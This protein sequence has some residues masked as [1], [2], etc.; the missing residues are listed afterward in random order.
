MCPSYSLDFSPQEIGFP[1]DLGPTM[2]VE[3]AENKSVF[4]SEI[5][6]IGSFLLKYFL[7]NVIIN[8]GTKN[9]SL[10]LCFLIRNKTSDEVYFL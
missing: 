8:S 3:P 7:G 1:I 2:F 10:F 9:V 6:C 5:K 4:S